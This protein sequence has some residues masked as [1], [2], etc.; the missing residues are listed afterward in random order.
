ML[1]KR[2]NSPPSSPRGFPDLE[3]AGDAP[4][5]IAL[6][7]SMVRTTSCSGTF[8]SAA[9]SEPVGRQ[10]AAP[11]DN[12]LLVALFGTLLLVITMTSAWSL[13]QR[14]LVIEGGLSDVRASMAALTEKIRE[15][16][17]FHSQSAS[18]LHAQGKQHSQQG[19]LHA[20]G[21]EAIKDHQK[22]ESSK[23]P[24]RRR[25]REPAAGV[26]Q[27][28]EESEKEDRGQHRA[29]G[30]YGNG[31]KSG[32]MRL[33]ADA[34]V[35]TK[36]GGGTQSVGFLSRTFLEDIRA[37][38][39][40][41]PMISY[42]HSGRRL[43][44]EPEATRESLQAIADYS[45]FR[46]EQELLMQFAAIPKTGS[47]VLI[48]GLKKSGGDYELDFAS[49]SADIQLFPARGGEGEEESKSR[50]RMQHSNSIIY[51]AQI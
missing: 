27:D 39:V 32:S 12:N 42:D 29:I 13:H 11:S 49:D 47:I 10:P 51:K 33:G 50:L 22:R 9:H 38:E 14:A 37:E 28:W 44:E 17:E 41:V 5:T 24:R 46:T 4:S 15:Q 3:A 6:K 45:I 26:R 23:L 25:R 16:G 34:L 48:T 40:L 30:R 31:F 7:P 1:T 2:T 19:K 43:E 8:A 21:L 35:L 20:Q 18:L 36:H